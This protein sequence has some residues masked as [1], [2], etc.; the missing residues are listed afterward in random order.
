MAV[1]PG[2]VLVGDREGVVVIP[3]HLAEEIALEALEMTEFEDFVTE[4][5]LAAWRRVKGR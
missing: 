2:D 4:Q 1:F 5:V 3:A